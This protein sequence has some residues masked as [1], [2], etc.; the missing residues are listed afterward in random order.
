MRRNRK[1]QEQFSKVSTGT[2]LE[3]TAGGF[4]KELLWV[5][6]ASAKGHP[7]PAYNQNI[8]F[9]GECARASN[10]QIL[11]QYT[12]DYCKEI[13]PGNYRVV[14]IHP[15]MVLLKAGKE[16]EFPDTTRLMTMKMDKQGIAIDSYPMLVKHINISGPL[17]DPDLVKRIYQ[18]GITWYIWV[19]GENNPVFCE[20]VLGDHLSVIQPL[21]Q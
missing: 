18:P 11:N 12:N 1:R 20:D 21:S 3:I 5:L 19:S 16:V 17:I 8:N 6:Q 2:Y 14:C 7:N 13:V 9:N 10:G 4:R 15:A